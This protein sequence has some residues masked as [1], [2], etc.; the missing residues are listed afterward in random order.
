M[1]STINYS[2][3]DY[4]RPKGTYK[5]PDWAVAVGWIMAS[6]AAMWIPLG[7][8]YHIIRYGQNWDVSILI[9]KTNDKILPN[10]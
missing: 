1:M 7:W 6:F 9:I 5:Y 8:L 2:E 4:K 3:L 10:T